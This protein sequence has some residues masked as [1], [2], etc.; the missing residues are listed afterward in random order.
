[1]NIRSFQSYQDTKQN[2]YI[3]KINLLKQ[4]VE[5]V[6]LCSDLLLTHILPLKLTQKNPQEN[7]LQ[8]IGTNTVY[9]L[10]R[11]LPK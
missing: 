2:R 8:K 1:M 9:I 4:T 3:F 10:L 7:L 6:K 5:I 11:L